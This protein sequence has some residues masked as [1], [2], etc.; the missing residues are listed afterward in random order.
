MKGK[1]VVI[2]QRRLTHY[3]VPLFEKLRTTL[4]D[5]GIQLRLL[6][7]EGTEEEGSKQDHGYLSWA[8]KLPT[9]YWLGGKICWQPTYRYLK[10]ADL[11]IVTQ[12][13][14]QIAN[15]LLILSPL[16]PKVA[17]WGHGVNFQSDNPHGLRERYKAWVSRRVD[18]WFAYTSLSAS[19]VARTGFDRHRI[20][21]LNNAVERSLP[22][23]RTCRN[24]V[25]DVT[26]LR[27][28]LGLGAGPVG[29]FV[30]SFHKNK[31]LDFLFAA[32]DA[33]RVQVPSFGFV[34]VGD[35][36]ERKS[37][38]QFCGARGWAVWAGPKFGAEKNLH[39]GAARVLINP[40]AVGLGI[41]DSFSMGLPIATTDCG[42][43]GPEIAYLKNGENGLMTPDVLS[44][45]VDGCVNLLTD[46]THRMRLR[47]GALQSAE[48]Y[49]LENMVGRFA[50]GVCE[51]LN[52]AN[53]SRGIFGASH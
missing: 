17:F 9:R 18:W 46:D 1:Q 43:H 53:T 11:V 27:A 26:A 20:T 25:K 35:G 36:P 48:K 34:F 52:V 37:V 45:F 50:K 12:E 6:V 24:F 39:L 44:D 23:H 3:R 51:A 15:Q 14:A 22:E 16:R 47:T 7:G 19:A 33:I 4:G 42:L 13:N 8:K 28:S 29:I 41:L 49:T 32:L 10:G 40:G 30:G 21:V 38:E 5:R 2:V 31:R